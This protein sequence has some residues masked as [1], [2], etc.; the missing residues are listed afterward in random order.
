M[1]ATNAFSSRCVQV[2]MSVHCACAELSLLLILIFSNNIGFLAHHHHLTVHVYILFCESPN[3][4]WMGIDKT[5][6][7]ILYMPNQIITLFAF[8]MAGRRNGVTMKKTIK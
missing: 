1:N 7:P 2:G 5:T 4:M 6:T 3:I 8:H